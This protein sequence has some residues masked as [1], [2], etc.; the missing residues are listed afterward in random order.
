MR[1]KLSTPHAY[2]YN[3]NLIVGKH[4]V[5]YH[6]LN[7]MFQQLS[8]MPENRKIKIGKVTPWFISHPHF[9]I[10]GKT[11]KLHQLFRLTQDNTIDQ[12]EILSFKLE[13]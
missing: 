3:L 10:H 8:V 13:S 1:E 5:W 9:T 2:F 4:V 11:E 7:N 6:H 12:N